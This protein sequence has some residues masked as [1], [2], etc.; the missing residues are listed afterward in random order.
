MPQPCVA[1]VGDLNLQYVVEGTG[2]WVVVIGGFATAYWQ[3]WSKYMPAL[4]R[5]YRVLAFDS[6]GSGLSDAPDYPYTT[7]LMADDTVGL[8]NHLGIESAHVIGRSLGGCV[9]QQ[10][11]LKNPDRVRSLAM[12]ASFA[13]IGNRGQAVVQ[14]WLDTITK[15]G[16]QGFFDQLM[17]YFYTAEYYESN[18]QEVERTIQALLASPRSERAFVNTGNAVLNHDVLDRLG[19]ILAPTILLCGAEDVITPARH[20]EEMGRRMREAEVHVI[21]RSAHGFLT[22]RPDSFDLIVQFLAKH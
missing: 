17:T 15:I 3:S 14:H 7:A 9:A 18:M 11:A 8:M 16:F 1:R 19:E 21:P 20:A 5:N 2:D 22:E 10:I 4:T 12:T 13:K 6:R